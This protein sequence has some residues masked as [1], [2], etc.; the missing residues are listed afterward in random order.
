LQGCQRGARANVIKPGEQ[1]NK[2]GGAGEE[3][4]KEGEQA[5]TN[6]FIFIHNNK[7]QNKGGEKAGNEAGKMSLKNSGSKSQ[8]SAPHE[9]NYEPIKHSAIPARAKSV[10]QLL[11][12]PKETS[13]NELLDNKHCFDI[14]T[15]VEVSRVLGNSTAVLAI[16]TQRLC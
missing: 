15:Y 14:D 6:N 7:K 1:T 10:N 16:W 11:H 13:S 8:R 2:A 5:K 12:L 3:G 4:E 9:S